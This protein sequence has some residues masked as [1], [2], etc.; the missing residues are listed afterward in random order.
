MILQLLFG[1]KFIVSLARAEFHI[2]RGLV[3]CLALSTV[4]GI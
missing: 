4:S 2:G 3:S 1:Y